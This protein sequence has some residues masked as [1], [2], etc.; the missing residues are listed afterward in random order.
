M[1]RAC[2]GGCSLPRSPP[3]H[4]QRT[5]RLRRW[6]PPRP[7]LRGRTLTSAG[8]PWRWRGEPAGVLAE[9][10]RHRIGIWG[11]GSWAARTLAAPRP[12]A[13]WSPQPS[14]RSRVVPALPRTAR[15]GSWRGPAASDPPAKCS[16][17]SRPAIRRPRAAGSPGLHPHGVELRGDRWRVGALPGAPRAPARSLVALLREQVDL[18]RQ[19]GKPGGTRHEHPHPRSS[20]RLC[21]Y[22]NGW[23]SCARPRLVGARAPKP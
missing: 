1:C 14:S 17:A 12:G 18:L 23:R 6:R 22:R 15:A 5:P 9:A 10:L 21:S 8:A 2:G 3:A 4:A 13:A 20:A 11:G 16:T 19:P 7:L